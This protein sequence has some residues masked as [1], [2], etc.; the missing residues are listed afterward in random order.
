MQ[1]A[2]FKRFGKLSLGILKPTSLMELYQLCLYH[3]DR[4]YENLEAKLQAC[5]TTVE[6]HEVDA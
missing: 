1:G 3:L 5:G 4:G 2:E 6:R